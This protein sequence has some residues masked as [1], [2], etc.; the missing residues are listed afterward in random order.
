MS[1]INII[2]IT[3]GV[4]GLG[5]G[6]YEYHIAQKWKRAELAGKLLEKLSDDPILARCC[7]FLDYAERPMAV[8][9][10]YSIFTEEKYFQHNWEVLER[11]LQHEYKKGSFGWQEVIYRD[12][13]DYFFTYLERINHFISIRLVDIAHVSNLKYWLEEIAHPRFTKSAV[14][15]DFVEGYEY[16]GVLQLMQRFEIQFENR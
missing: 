10:E 16:D 1:I 2:T 15:M 7:I 5:F 8:P 3:I 6:L 4:V 12:S 13:F 11:G 14:F 9:S